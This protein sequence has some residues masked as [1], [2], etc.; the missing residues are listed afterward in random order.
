MSKFST[1]ALLVSLAVLTTTVAAFDWTSTAESAHQHNW[2][3]PNMGER[4][5]HQSEIA[6]KSMLERRAKL[7]L[8]IPKAT[9]TADTSI[10]GFL[11]QMLG[12]AYGLQYDAKKPGTCYTSIE[13]TAL[14]IE[15]LLSLL[16]QFYVPS[17]WADT[18]LS[19]QNWVQLSTTVYSDCDIQKFFNTVTALF[20]G[21]GSSTLVARIAGGFIFE[22]P[23]YISQFTSD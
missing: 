10:P 6:R 22:L 1:V 9:T 19:L 5:R 8:Y 17:L 2:N 7:G 18:V 21:E 14:E 4:V 11:G 20:T 16:E 23:N 15:S 13:D 12:F 3:V